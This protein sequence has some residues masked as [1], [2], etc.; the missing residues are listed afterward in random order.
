MTQKTTTPAISDEQLL[1]CMHCG[2]CLPTCPTYSLTLR[3]RS[4]PRG[5]IRLIKKF[6]GGELGISETFVEEMNFCLNCRACETACPAGVDYHHLLEFARVAVRSNTKRSVPQKLGKALLD[7]LF[8]RPYILKKLARVLYFYQKSGLERLVL[9]S[10]VLRLMP[11]N[12]DRTARL[13][14]RISPRP[15]SEILPEKIPAK[16]EKKYTVALLTGCVQDVSFAEVTRHA[17]E[18]LAWNGCEV[19]VPRGQVC[20]GSLHGH[21]GDLETA[22]ALFS[23]NAAAFDVSRFDA[24][25]VTAAGCGSFMK[26]YRDTFAAAGEDMRQQAEA[27]SAKV[28]DIHEFLAEIPLKKPQRHLPLTVTYHDACHLAHAQKITRQPRQLLEM[29]PGLTLVPLPESTW[30]CGSAGTY[31]LTHPE[32]AFALLERKVS[33]I[34]STCA[35]VVASANPGCSIQIAYGLKEKGMQT[36]VVHPISLLWQAYGPGEEKW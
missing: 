17:A 18:V 5:R 32:P 20:C 21:I 35:T 27:F 15:A 29:I 9:A 22:G 31:N 12:L 3:E 30:C 16:G 4:S 19:H 26:E 8:T 36:E 25:I 1:Q 28:R 13:S 2:M 14:P 33:N 10:G 23:R 11:G 24:I 7:K 6:S 34:A